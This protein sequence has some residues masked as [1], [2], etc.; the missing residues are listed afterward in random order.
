MG[1][2]LRQWV[3]SRKD[4]HDRESI[5]RDLRSLLS[6]SLGLLVKGSL[7][8]AETAAMQI[9]ARGVMT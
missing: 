8:I 4:C 9:C 1:I 7:I 2:N 3:E 5:T 6:I